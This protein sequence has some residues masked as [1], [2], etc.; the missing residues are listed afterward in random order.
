MTVLKNCRLLPSLTE[1]Y[2]QPTGDIIIEG[3]HIQRICPPGT[4][5]TDSGTTIDVKGATVL[6]GFFDL[7]AHLMFANQDYNA[8]VLRSQNEYMLDSMEYARVYLK[9]GYTTI[10]DCGNDFYVGV[11]IKNAIERGII[12]GARIITSG[13]IIS[14]IAKGNKSFGTLY[15][16]VDR[17]EDMMRV[18]RNEVV[19][20]VDFIKY[21][22]T[23]AVLNESGEPGEMVTTPAEIQAI[24][25]AADSL[26][27]YVAAH[28]HGTE[29]IK[30]AIIHG[31]RTIEHASY[32]DDECIELLVKHGCR[33][34]LVPTL[35]IAFSLFNHF[36]E[37][38]IL[39]EFMEKAK[40]ACEH[41]IE[42]MKM[43]DAAGITIGWGTDFDRENFEKYVGLEFTSRAKTGL[44]N[45]AILRQATINS[46]KIVG[47]EEKLGTVKCGKYADLAVV[48]GKPDEDLTVMKKLPLYVLKEGVLVAGT[49][50]QQE[51][52]YE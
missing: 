12:Q 46:A 10:R 37:G 38:T 42:G 32:L 41:V 22:I 4:A 16:E 28:C 1:G 29:G 21:M 48:D 2:D 6:P 39:P 26:H 36:F 43:A 34:S 8:S 45:E 51:K 17:P 49:A 9:H 15:E 31:V 18:C 3:K 20:G 44:P 30:Q 5:P 7:H 14:P 35:S 40:D 11:S 52:S 25:E 13:K 23:G 47:L 27:T 50:L 19:H 33:S 24:V